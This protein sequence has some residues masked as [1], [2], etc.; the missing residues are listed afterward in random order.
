MSSNIEDFVRAVKEFLERVGSQ[1]LRFLDTQAALRPGEWY[2]TEQLRTR[3]GAHS[4]T[5]QSWKA[6]GLRSS[7]PGTKAEFYS[8]DDVMQFFREHPTLDE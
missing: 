2:T 5:L 4:S 6:L 8:S 1:L 3:T 7:K